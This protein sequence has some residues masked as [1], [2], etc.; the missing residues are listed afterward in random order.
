MSD[1][2]RN[3]RCMWG[4]VGAMAGA[5]LFTSACEKDGNNSEPNPQTASANSATNAAS[6]TSAATVN[7]YFPDGL[8]PNSA[9]N[10]IIASKF[11][12][13]ISAAPAGIGE[14]D[15]NTVV[16]MGDSITT[17]DY[18]GPLASMTGKNVVDEGKTG[19]D[20]SGGAARVGAVLAKH[21]PAYVCILYGAN[22]V[23]GGVPASQVVANLGAMI[24]AARA[25][26]TIPIVGTLTPMSGAYSQ[27]ATAAED[28]SAQ[29]RALAG[30]TSTAL[31]DLEVAF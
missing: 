1:R 2:K 27:F 29:I 13:H 18:P 8:H 25:R 24:S 17:G 7:P 22:D 10:A 28:V 6:T 20:S 16:C 3:A 15:P 23:I 9:A 14:N 19:E 31:A 11:G 4:S 5:L 26:N 12:A 21:R 30:G